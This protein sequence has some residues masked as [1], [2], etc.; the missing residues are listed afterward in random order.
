MPQGCNIA[1]FCL[2]RAK[3]KQNAA[4][5]TGGRSY[6]QESC[7]D[8][9]PRHFDRVEVPDTTK[10]GYAHTGGDPDRNQRTMRPTHACREATIAPRMELEYTSGP[11]QCRPY[12]NLSYREVSRA[13]TGNPGCQR[14]PGEQFAGNYSSPANLRKAA[15]LIR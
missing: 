11:R 10:G 3:E 4:A 14:P 12:C 13:P 2:P 1:V 6:G 5:L 9:R 15:S 7:P 8:R